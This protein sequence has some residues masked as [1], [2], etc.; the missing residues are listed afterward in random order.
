MADPKFETAH[1]EPQDGRTRIPPRSEFEAKTGFTR[2]IRVGGRIDVAGTTGVEAD[3]TVSD[4]AGKQADRCFAQIRAAIEELGGTMEDVTRVR[5]FTCDMGDADAISAAFTRVLAH[6]RPTG[7]MV[8]ITGLYDTRLKVEIE[9][10]AIVT[11]E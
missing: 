1:P 7:T 10:E 2:A 5:M 11:A 6:V 4:D 3:G 9:A 8:G